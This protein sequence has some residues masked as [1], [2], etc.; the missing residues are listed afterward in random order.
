MDFG[1]GIPIGIQM[2]V[3][4]TSPFPPN[5]IVQRSIL[6]CQSPISNVTIQLFKSPP[7]SVIGH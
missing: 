3:F 6:F 2:L 7:L 4:E 1:R 5:I